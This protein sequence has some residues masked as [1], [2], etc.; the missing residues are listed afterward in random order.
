MTEIA[1]EQN[2]RP[3]S[4]RP[5]LLDKKAENSISL[6][7]GAPVEVVNR[8][9]LDHLNRSRGTTS[10]IPRTVPVIVTLVEPKSLVFL[11]VSRAAA[12]LQRLCFSVYKAH[13]SRRDTGSDAGRK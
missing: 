4:L 13:R 6:R 12:R 10:E 9:S 1:G 5:G 3:A 11:A 2:K 8:A 7:R